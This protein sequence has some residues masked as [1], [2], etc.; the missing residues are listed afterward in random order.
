MHVALKG[1]RVVFQP[2]AIARDTFS[3]LRGREFARKVRTLSGNL[4]LITIAPWL[5]TSRNP[6][7]FRFISHKIL[8]LISPFLLILILLVSAESDRFFFKTAFGFQILFYA[9]SAFAAAIPAARRFRVLGIIYTFT[10]L[11]LAV[12]M[13]FVRFTFRRASPW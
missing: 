4:Q 1:K 13:A 6:L 9:C 5:L 2:R 11:N 10:T 3:E 12:L 8:R 7:L